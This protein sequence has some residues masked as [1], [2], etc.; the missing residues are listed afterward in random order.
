MSLLEQ[1]RFLTRYL[2]DEAVRHAVREGGVASAGLPLDDDDIEYLES[3]SLDDL[4]RTA[5]NIRE[6]RLN[7]R[8][9]EFE[10]FVKHLGLHVP[11][12]EVLEDFDR[13][14]TTGL[15][16]RWM[17]V[18]RFVSYAT[19]MLSV[20]SLPDYLF[21]LLRFNYDVAVLADRP[22]VEP[23]YLVEMFPKDLDAAM[24]IEV[25]Q[26]YR[27]RRFTYDV[28]TIASTD[29]AESRGDWAPAPCEVL[30]QKNWTVPKRTRAFVLGGDDVLSRLVHAGSSSVLDLLAGQPVQ[31]F[32]AIVGE[33]ESY[34][35]ARVVAVSVP[36]HLRVPDRAP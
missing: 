31:S 32:P 16:A 12:Q 7:K 22:I 11:L 19:R 3:L 9:A 2:R 33:L 27:V 20:R 14:Y 36:P 10:P 21:D 29:P 28:V 35:D 26:P 13:R 15:Q 30:L 17:E 25:C 8:A 4:D 5:S 24:T 18:D 6:E 1:Q 23:E 34:H